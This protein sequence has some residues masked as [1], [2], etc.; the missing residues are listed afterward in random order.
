MHNTLLT[1]LAGLSSDPFVT[2]CTNW[3]TRRRAGWMCAQC[4]GHQA[5]TS[6][7]ALNFSHI[8][9]TQLGLKLI[10]LS[11]ALRIRD[12]CWLHSN[13][14]DHRRQLGFWPN[15]F[16]LIQ[17]AWEDLRGLET[18]PF[19][20]VAAKDKLYWKGF[21]DTWL[22]SKQPSTPPVLPGP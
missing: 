15:S 5:W 12:T 20:E 19:W 1:S 14:R 17:L 6:I 16:R 9:D 7:H 18:S 11:V 10:A 21:I 2:S 8:G 22:R 4:L 3:V 13:W